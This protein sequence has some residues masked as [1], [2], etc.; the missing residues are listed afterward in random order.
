MGGSHVNNQCI[1]A[2]FL[3]LNGISNGFLPNILPRL[4][5]YVQAKLASLAMMTRMTLK[6]SEYAFT[7]I[8]VLRSCLAEQLDI[9]HKSA[10]LLGQLVC[11]VY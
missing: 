8:G 3:L 4:S 9:L 6:L 1:Y 5:F 11:F 7:T 2:N 10:G